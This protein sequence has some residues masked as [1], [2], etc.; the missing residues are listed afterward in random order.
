[1]PYLGLIHLFHTPQ[2]HLL[3]DQQDLVEIE[4]RNAEL[5]NGVEVP[6][7]HDVKSPRLAY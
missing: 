5:S 7:C 1:M 4:E 3:A 2:V 6:H